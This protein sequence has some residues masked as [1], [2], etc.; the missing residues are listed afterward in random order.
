MLLTAVI[1]VLLA[2]PIRQALTQKRG[3]DWVVSQNG[4]VSFSYKYNS[5]TRQW[6]HEATLPYPRWLIDAMGI[7]FFTSVDTVVLDNK[8]VVDLSPLVDLHNLRCLGIY[9]EIKQGLDF[10]P[11]SE[12]PHLQ[13]LHLD[14][15]G[16]SSDELE[17]VRAL[18]PYVRVQSAGH[19]DS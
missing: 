1:A 5:T 18:L 6:V 17:R 12:L 11:L 9:I 8:E 10:S 15:T 19:P 16:I 13:S 2:M 4:H 14:Y 3:R 7:D